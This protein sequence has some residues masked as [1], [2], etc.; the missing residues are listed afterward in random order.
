[1]LSAAKEVGRFVSKKNMG[2][3]DINGKRSTLD[4]PYKAFLQK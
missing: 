2:I 3:N 4:G 1:M